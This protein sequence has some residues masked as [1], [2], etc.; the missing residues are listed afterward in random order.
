MCEYAQVA[1]VHQRFTILLG[2]EAEVIIIIIL[3]VVTDLGQ[4]LLLGLGFVS[5]DVLELYFFGLLLVQFHFGIPLLFF[6][7]ALC[8]LLPLLLIE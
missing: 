2:G 5:V 7:I 8:L 6:G 4:V 3:V 1:R